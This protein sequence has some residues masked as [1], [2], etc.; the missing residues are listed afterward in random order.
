MTPNLRWLIGLGLLLSLAAGRVC[1]AEARQYKI[2]MKIGEGSCSK[3]LAEPTLVVLAGQPA[4]IEWAPGQRL[5]MA[6]QPRDTHHINVRMDSVVEFGTRRQQKE[7]TLMAIRPGQTIH[8]VIARDDQQNALAWVDLKVTEVKNPVA[9]ETSAYGEEEQEDQSVPTKYK[10]AVPTWFWLGQLAWALLENE[11]LGVLCTQE[12]HSQ[13]AEVLQS[14]MAQ[15]M[16]YVPPQCL[17]MPTPVPQA[18]CPA[19]PLAPWNRPYENVHGE[20]P[21][22]LV[23]VSFPPAPVGMPMPPVPCPMPLCIQGAPCLPQ[24]LPLCPMMPPP[25]NT[26]MAACCTPP[27]CTTTIQVVQEK[28]RHQMVVH[29]E[30]NDLKMLVEQ[31]EVKMADGPPLKVTVT[32]TGEIEA[33]CSEMKVHA[34]SL[35]V[36]GKERIVLEGKVTVRQGKHAGDDVIRTSA[37]KSGTSVSAE[38]VILYLNDGHLEIPLPH[39]GKE[40]TTKAAP[41]SYSCPKAR[42]GCTCTCP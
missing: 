20:M 33:S 37:E 23:G 27:S 18:A 10:I 32:R 6:V 34:Q 11:D 36:E 38:K 30:A 29:H 25:P 9:R 40:K 1:S 42:Q 21:T 35:T 41:E 31:M 7:S 8:Q 15:P 3:V 19:Y 17:T 24:P 22:P 5:E 2:E 4:T 39:M 13:N 28:G 12:W 16:P 26:L 14:G